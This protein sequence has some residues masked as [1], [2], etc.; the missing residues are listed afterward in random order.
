MYNIII[1]NDNNWYI[2]TRFT[3][4]RVPRKRHFDTVRIA[5]S[6][7]KSLASRNKN[8]LGKFC[9]MFVARLIAARLKEVIVWSMVKTDGRALVCSNDIV[10]GSRVCDRRTAE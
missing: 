5:L 6:S 2:G 7:R 4:A 8:K 9:Q 3:S 10:A 1:N